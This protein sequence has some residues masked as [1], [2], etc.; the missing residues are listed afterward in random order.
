MIPDAEAICGAYLREQDSL[1]ALSVNVAT[2]LP[3]TFTRPWVRVI[4]LDNPAVNGSRTDHLIEYMLQF[5]CYAGSEG[6][7][8]E[9]SL[10]TRT[11]REAL[12]ALPQASLDDAVVTGVQF[13]SCPRIP[14]TDFEPARERYALSALV[15]MHP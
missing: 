8:P 14:D 9:A 4:Q 12:R 10:V 6:G 11:V 5:D 13:I 1:V 15:W 7:S 3:R 2:Q